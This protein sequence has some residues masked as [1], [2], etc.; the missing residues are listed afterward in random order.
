MRLDK[1]ICETKNLTRAEAKRCIKVGMV[2]INQQLVTQAATKV[3]SSDEVMFNDQ[4]V[5]LIGPQYI[6]LH[7]PAGYV[8]STQDEEYPCVMRLIHSPHAHKLHIAGRLDVDTTGLVLLTDDGQWSHKVTSPKHACEKVYQVTLAE[9]IAAEAVEQFA[10]GI[11]LRN[12]HKATLPAQLVIHEPLSVTVTL[13]EG[14][15]HQVK[16]MFAAI[17]NKVVGLHRANVGSI[18]LQGLAEQEWRYLTADEVASFT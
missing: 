14:K 15:Y 1:F 12:E 6:V 7:K 11:M 2:K 10:E 17:G 8:C 9:P 3:A 18:S 4:V 5:S 13:S 16:R